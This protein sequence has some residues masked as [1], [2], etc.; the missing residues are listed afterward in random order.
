MPPLLKIE[1][2]SSATGA[3]LASRR[4]LGSSDTSQTVDGRNDHLSPIFEYCILLNYRSCTLPSRAHRNLSPPPLADTLSVKFLIPDIYSLNPATY[5]VK[6][7]VQ[8]VLL[9]D[10]LLVSKRRRCRKGERGRLVAERCW[11]LGEDVIVDVKDTSGTTRGWYWPIN[12]QVR[13]LNEHY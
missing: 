8:L 7:A 11:A 1:E 9:D 5:K 6:Y 13:R 2:A 10:A 12:S 3:P 4:L